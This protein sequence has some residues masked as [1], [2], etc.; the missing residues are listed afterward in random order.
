M[1]C[2]FSPMNQPSSAMALC[3]LPALDR[4]PSLL[5]GAL[6]HA[7]IFLLLFLALPAN[8][9]SFNFSSFS[10]NMQ[11]I[12]YY[13]HA[14]SANGV[15]QLT[16][17]Q[18]DAAITNSTGRAF[19]AQPVRLWDAASGESTDFTTHFSFVINALH[20][21]SPGDGLAF[22]LV[23]VGAEAV[24]AE[25]F[26]GYLGLFS[27]SSAR[28]ASA[29][30]LVAVEFD[31]FANDW[32]PSDNHVGIDVNSIRSAAT[33]TWNSSMK[34]G[35][36][37]HAW[38]NYNSRAKK[39]SC[40]L[41][42]DQKPFFR[43]D[44][45][46]SHPVDL[47]E[48]LPE[49]VSVGFSAATGDW[50]EVHNILTWEF[51][52][53]L[54]VREKSKVARVVGTAAGLVFAAAAVA[55]GLLAWK[56]RAC[57]EVKEEDTVLDVSIDG[58]FEKG[59]GPKKFPYHQLAAATKD[60]SQEGKLGEGGFGSVYRGYLSGMKLEVAIK[61]ISRGSTQGRKEYVSEVK[62]ISRLRHRNLVQLIGW[63]HDRGEFL[64]VYEYLPNGSLDSHLFTGSKGLLPWPTRYK[65]AMGV[66]SALMYL[67]EE[68]EQC[69]VHRDVKSSNVIL[70][71][72]FNAKLGDFGLARLVDHGRA[73]QTT[74]LAGTMGYLAPECVTTGKASKES[75]VY[76]FGVVALEIACG[77]RV[78]EPQE[79]QEKVRLVQWVWGCYGRGRVLEAAD[80]RLGG[81]FD[82]KEMARLMVVGLWCAH[83]DCGRRPSMRQAI[84]VLSS[85][86]ALPELPSQ[87][88]VATYFAPPLNLCRFTY[89]SAEAGGAV[90][91]AD[92]GFSGYTTNSS[93][94]TASAASSQTSCLLP[95]KVESSLN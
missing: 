67:H 60:F 50:I 49:W 15:L 2:L 43:G 32:D 5:G 81:E 44:W 37:G 69:V 45:S 19:Y 29:N 65:I 61:R 47:K 21:A 14:F 73:S 9:L 76:S 71:S 42:Y 39:L 4:P 11:D 7:S 83:P 70:D 38:V 68:W 80:G 84:A 24:P 41:T 23:P 27:K 57:R 18:R 8:P 13:G 64:L 90:S 25:S 35:T 34:V 56:K 92:S 12:V 85:E 86:A 82:G 54:E 48:M 94:S 79:D 58:E 26:G 31:T 66:A 33:L 22:F 74:V 30:R 75:D 55:C 1:I 89:T 51:S 63:C 87:M 95:H 62:T 72:N 88:P 46:L 93:T 59:S 3:V 77:R 36:T 40:F 53:S 10:Q 6:A 28:N 91:T 52:S 20:S 78:V 16:K 17:N